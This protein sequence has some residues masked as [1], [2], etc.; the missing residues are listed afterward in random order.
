MNQKIPFHELSSRIASVT[1][2]SDESAETFVKNFFDILSDELIKGE[3]VKIKGLGLFSFNGH[4]GEASIVFEADKDLADAI[5]APFSIFENVVLHEN[6]TDTMLSELDGD[7]RQDDE[8][9]SS[10]NIILIEDTDKII[11]ISDEHVPQIETSSEE[12]QPTDMNNEVQSTLPITT[13]GIEN[14]EIQEAVQQPEL[15]TVVLSST[16]N[17]T[18]T[19][20]ENNDIT[21]TV[22]PVIA[23]LMEE[24]EEY[25]IHKETSTKSNSNFWWGLGIGIIVGL[26][27]GACGVYLAIDHLFPGGQSTTANL[28]ENPST[29][30]EEAIVS[31][32]VESMQNAATDSITEIS[33]TE[34]VVETQQTTETPLTDTHV[35]N[36]ITQDTIRRGYL[37]HDMAKKFYGSKDFWV[38]IYEENKDKIGNPNNMQPGLVLTIPTPEKYGIVSGNASS[39]KQAK[40]KAGEI[41]AKYPR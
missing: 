12:L 26:A 28:I 36:T 13:H 8:Q 41:L 33:A 20:I 30:I 23:P 9:A 14:N 17:N 27:L 38:Y 16:A 34:S 35:A 7:N 32:V 24:P 31:E 29:E 10:D 37:I 21:N 40:N 18:S 1:G 5:N 11:S 6:V 2:I 19:D 4:N 15:Q 39:L 3:S 22:E 25:V